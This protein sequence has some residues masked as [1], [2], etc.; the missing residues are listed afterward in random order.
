MGKTIVYGRFEWEESKALIN[1]QK[2][3]IA[4]IDILPIFDDPLFWEQYDAEHSTENEHR[5]IG[6]GKLRGIAVIVSCYTE[7]DN[8][9]RIIRARIS[10][11]EEE[12]RYENWCKQYYS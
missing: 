4:F 6:V 12:R 11:K 5:F 9:I 2:H 8:R 7:R 3:G 1:E 10:T